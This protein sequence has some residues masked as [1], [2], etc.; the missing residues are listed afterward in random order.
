M[1]KG[2]AGLVFSEEVSLLGLPMANFPLCPHMVF[3]LCT[4]LSLV[5]KFP[6]LIRTPVILDWA[7]L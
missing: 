6:F 1:T 4:H 2:S 7:S 3:S 5:C